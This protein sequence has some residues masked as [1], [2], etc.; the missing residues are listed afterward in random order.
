[1]DSRKSGR[2]ENFV[3]SDPRKIEGEGEESSLAGCCG[4][5]FEFGSFGKGK[6]AVYYGWG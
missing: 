4:N 2:R 1:M 3:P 6:E 5:R